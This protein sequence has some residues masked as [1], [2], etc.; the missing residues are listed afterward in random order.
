MLT[1]GNFII[2]NKPPSG[3]FSK[4]H[5][6]QARVRSKADTQT[7]PHSAKLSTTIF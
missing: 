6:H 3:Q 7:Q 2:A 1:F 4:I 5:L